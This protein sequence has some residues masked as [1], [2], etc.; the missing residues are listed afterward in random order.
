MTL[1]VDQA[2]VGTTGLLAATGMPESRARASA[3]SIVV[4][5]LWGRGS[6]GLLRLPY[7]LERLLAGG[8]NPRAELVQVTDT[9]P[10]VCYDGQAGLGHWQLREAAELAAERAG[11]YGLAAVSVGNSGH[12]GALG[13]YASPGLDAGLLSIIFSN[14]PAVMPPWNGHA[15]VL[16]TSP[17]A[18]GIPC[19]PDPAVVDLATSAVARGRIAKRAAQGQPLEPGWAFDAAGAPTTDPQAA[20]AGMLAP[21]GGA[22]GFAL[23]FLVEALTGGMVGPSLATDVS[24]MFRA[25]DAARPQQIAHLVVTF[26]AGCFDSTGQGGTGRLDALAEAVT[27]AGGRLPGAGKCRLSRLDGSLTIGVDD[28]LDEQLRAWGDRLGVTWPAGGQGSMRRAE[29]TGGYR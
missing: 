28:T 16:S 21:L 27:K 23:A 13:V 17:L 6:H 5:D 12:C 11:R 10:A 20:L 22:K 14:G 15:P 29:R 26:D 7:Y 18:A 2:V 25:Q 4:A 24:D 9:G 3:E 19:H 1:T 8:Y